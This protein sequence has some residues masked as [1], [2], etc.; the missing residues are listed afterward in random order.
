ME[1][2]GQRHGPATLPPGMN[3]YLLYMRL[4]GSPGSVWTSAENL[5]PTGIRG[6]DRPDRSESLYRLRYSVIIKYYINCYH[7]LTIA[8]YTKYPLK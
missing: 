4:G 6:P 1:V 8:Y 7:K 2:G 5:D 3:R